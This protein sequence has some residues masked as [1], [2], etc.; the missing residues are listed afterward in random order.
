MLC[1]LTLMTSLVIQAS[2]G[3]LQGSG[4]LLMASQ[5]SIASLS[6][7]ATG[8][9]SSKNALLGGHGMWLQESV[10]CA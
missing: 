5:W 2:D 7:A 8:H 3:W 9:V 6:V 1:S 10:M 4:V